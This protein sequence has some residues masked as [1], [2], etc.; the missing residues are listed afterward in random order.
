V[1]Q[2]KAQS[3]EGEVFISW[4]SKNFAVDTFGWFMWEGIEEGAWGWSSK[5]DQGWEGGRW[6]RVDR[7]GVR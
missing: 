7:D 1:G 3:M 6:G 5:I 4:G 2:V